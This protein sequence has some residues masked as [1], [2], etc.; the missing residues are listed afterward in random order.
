M[1]IE[2]SP[3]SSTLSDPWQTP[4][5]DKSLP[6][7]AP[8]KAY[9]WTEYNSAATLIYTRDHRKADEELSKFDVGTVLG[10]DL[11]WKPTYYRGGRENPVALVQ[12]ANYH[13]ILLLQISAMKGRSSYLCNYI[14]VII[15]IEFPSKLADILANPD[16][17]KAGVAIQS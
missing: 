7:P 5:I 8:T 2:Q 4:K 3:S 15:F 17:V 16:I 12:I 13:S 1:S 14:I 9:S 6:R 10:F 11:E